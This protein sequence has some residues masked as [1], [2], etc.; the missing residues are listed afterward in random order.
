MCTLKNSPK[1]YAVYKD[2]RKQAGATTTTT[3]TTDDF[4]YGD[5]PC[6]K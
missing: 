3:T 5:T 4:D 6:G 1:G 2:I